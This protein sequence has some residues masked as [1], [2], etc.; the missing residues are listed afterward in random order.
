VEIVSD[1]TK[2]LVIRQHF[3][4][5]PV[6]IDVLNNPLCLFEENYLAI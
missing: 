2:Q 6:Y 5:V 1:T 3:G 4:L